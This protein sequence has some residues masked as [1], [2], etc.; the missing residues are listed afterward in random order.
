MTDRFVKSAQI[1][2]QVN[3]LPDYP[4]AV[5]G[6]P[7]ASDDDAALRAKAEIAVQQLVPILTRRRHDPVRA[8][9]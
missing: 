7:V 3:G 4:F 1:V 8:P 2:A 5:I 6:H 9:S